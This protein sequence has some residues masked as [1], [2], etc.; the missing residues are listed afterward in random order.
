MRSSTDEEDRSHC[1]LQNLERMF[2][3]VSPGARLCSYPPTDISAFIPLQS[4]YRRWHS[5]NPECR[6]PSLPAWSCSLRSLM[7]NRL[8]LAL[9]EYCN[10]RFK[11]LAIACVVSLN[12]TGVTDLDWFDLRHRYAALFLVLSYLVSWSHTLSWILLLCDVIPIKAK[13]SYHL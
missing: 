8:L 2:L 9:E 7:V 5:C 12:S 13:P 3:E 4:L 11:G 1:S 6:Y 10:C